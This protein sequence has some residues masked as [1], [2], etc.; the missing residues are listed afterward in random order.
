MLYR[1]LIPEHATET[2]PRGAAMLE[3]NRRSALVLVSGEPF[4]ECCAQAI[5]HGRRVALS[6]G[7]IEVG[8]YDSLDGE[9]RAHR[10]GL[11]ILARWLEHP[12]SRNDLLA[13]DNRDE[14]R[15][16]ARRLLYQGRCAE[17]ARIDP[18]R[19]GL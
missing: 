10:H 4:G 12:V 14:R 5:Q 16:R 6:H 11:E 19:M 1:V 9:L 15:A 7:C 17:A 18:G 2:I 13:C 3:Y 8:Y